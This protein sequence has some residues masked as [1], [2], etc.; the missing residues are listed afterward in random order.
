MS[1]LLLV[2]F[3]TLDSIVSDHLGQDSTEIVTDQL[4][5]KE[6]IV[7]YLAGNAKR[8][9]RALQRAA[10]KFHTDCFAFDQNDMKVKPY[11]VI[12]RLTSSSSCW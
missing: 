7:A 4:N 12:L 5:L 3:D 8:D 1:R 6:S 2:R 9:P 10:W 11:N